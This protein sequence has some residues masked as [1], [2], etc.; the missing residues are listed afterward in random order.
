VASDDGRASIAAARDANQRDGAAAGERGP[1]ETLPA[2]VPDHVRGVNATTES[3]LAGGLDG[4]L[5]DAV[6]GLLGSE[7]DARATESAR[8]NGGEGASAAVV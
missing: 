2:P 6:A 7:S 5:G 8:A 3:V 1:P 4:R